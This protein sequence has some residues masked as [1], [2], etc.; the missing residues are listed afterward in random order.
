[1]TKL[2]KEHGAFAAEHPQIPWR[3][4]KNMRNRLAHVYFDIDLEVVWG[5][6]TRWIPELLV[7]LPVIRAA[8]LE[9]C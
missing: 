4:I 8:A 9:R 7:R 5:S 1:M 6:A 3:S 2:L